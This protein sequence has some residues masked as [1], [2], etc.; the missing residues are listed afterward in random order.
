MQQCSVTTRIDIV[1]E[2]LCILVF[3]GMS[4]LT[5]TSCS[6]SYIISISR[7]SQNQ[8]T[9]TCTGGSD[10]TVGF[11]LNGSSVSF[12]MIMDRSFTFEIDRT[13]EGNY[14]CGEAGGPNSLPIPIVGECS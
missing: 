1:L 13:L 3:L 12:G 10:A 11:F 6:A 4:L 7:M 8:I 9:L 5:C 14:A 2:M